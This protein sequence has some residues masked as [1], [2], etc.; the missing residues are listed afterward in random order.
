M[1]ALEPAWTLGNLSSLIAHGERRR[2]G[3]NEAIGD[4]PIVNGILTWYY[5]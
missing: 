5:Q 2:L 1:L 4:I 3:M